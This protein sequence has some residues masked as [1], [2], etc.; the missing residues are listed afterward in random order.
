MAKANAAEGAPVPAS[1]S[2]VRVRALTEKGFRRVGRLFTRDATDIPRDQL[3][4]EQLDT[5]KAEPLLLVDE[6]TA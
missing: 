1:Q 4:E 2:I 6:I 3:T 5:L